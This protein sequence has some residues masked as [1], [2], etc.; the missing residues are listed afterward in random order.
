MSEQEREDRA[1]EALIVLAMRGI[2]H[3]CLG[4][5]EIECAGGYTDTCSV[6]D[7]SGLEPAKAVHL[8]DEC[9]YCGKPLS[10]NEK[11]MHGMHVD[12]ASMDKADYDR[13][14]AKDSD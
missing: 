14:R 10:L 9:T 8:P 12:C 6:C 5:G 13:D 3:Q 7:G 1:L 11:Q 2:C 4:D